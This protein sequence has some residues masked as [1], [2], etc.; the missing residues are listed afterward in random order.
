MLMAGEL[1]E[2]DLQSSFAVQCEALAEAKPDALLL[3]TM[4]DLAEARIALGAAKETGLPV[5]VS[6]AFDTGKNRDRTMTGVTPEQAARA[7]EEA[8]ADAVGANC[9]NGVEAFPCDLR[10]DAR[11]ERAAIVD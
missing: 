2:D 8:G 5:V 7:M 6:F 11:G 4:S 1:S 10:P 3:E 9:G